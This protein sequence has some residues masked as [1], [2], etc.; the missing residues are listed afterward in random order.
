MLIKLSSDSEYGYNNCKLEECKE[1]EL[2]NIEN[3]D[4]NDKW[5]EQDAFNHMGETPDEMLKVFKINPEEWRLTIP[6]WCLRESVWM[7]TQ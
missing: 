6:A 4:P 2:I 5:E 1:P 3:W 7:F